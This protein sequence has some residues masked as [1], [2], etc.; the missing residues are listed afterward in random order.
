MSAPRIFTANVALNVPGEGVKVYLI[1]EAVPDWATVGD[2]ASQG[3]TKAAQT[4]EKV[5]PVVVSPA[6]ENIGADDDSDEETYD[7]WTK[8]V[9]RTEVDGRQLEVPARATKDELIAALEADDLANPED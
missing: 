1:G 7:D 2:H 9:L 5:A 4:P 3:V 6:L 8:A